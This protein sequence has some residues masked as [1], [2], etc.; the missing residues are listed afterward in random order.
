MTVYELCTKLPAIDVLRS[1]CQALAVLER[2]ID[3][4]E[5]S[6]VYTT[7]WGDGE[8]LRRG[9]YDGDPD[10]TAMLEILLDDIV[11]Q[12]LEFA[13]DYY[14][15]ETNRASVEDIVRHRPLTDA[16]VQA[17][18]PGITVADLRDDLAVIGYPTLGGMS[19]LH[20]S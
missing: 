13:D 18:N 4:G 12:D 3:R 8:A 17:L 11:E 16:V 6:Y 15:M 14:E 7:T 2:I 19:G 20:R 10:G 1:R 9:P 5:P